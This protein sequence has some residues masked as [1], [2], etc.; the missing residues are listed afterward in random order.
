[1]VIFFSSLQGD[2]GS[3]GPPGLPGTV[4]K[5]VFGAVTIFKA[6]PPHKFFRNDFQVSYFSAETLGP[7]YSEIIFISFREAIS[8][9]IWSFY[10]FGE[11]VP[12]SA[13]LRKTDQEYINL[14]LSK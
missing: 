13:F 7:I 11:V 8:R 12:S 1:M 9:C 3:P 2:T 4:S 10:F 6:L 5:I 14:L